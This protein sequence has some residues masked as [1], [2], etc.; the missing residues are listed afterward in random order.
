MKQLSSIT[1]R[2]MLTL[3]WKERWVRVIVLTLLPIGVIDT[4][5]TIAMASLYGVEIEFNPIT[6]E[7][8]N[9]GLWLPWAALNVLGFT[10]FCMMAGSYYLHTRWRPGGPDTFWF[11]FIIALRIGM[12]AYN[13]TFYYMPFVITVYPP[14]WAGFIAF[15]ISLYVMNKLLMRKHDISWSQAKYYVKSRYESYKDSRL[16][17][18]ATQVP[19]QPL[20]NPQVKT[21]AVEREI[22]Q[23]LSGGEVKWYKSP[24]PKRAFFILMAGFSYILMGVAIEVI[25]HVSGL[26]EWSTSHGPFFILNDFTGPPIMASFL[27]I[28]FFMSLSLYFILKAFSTTQEL[29]L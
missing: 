17:S 8:L 19:G 1:A 16:I 5:Y 23:D 13:V 10:F 29:P 9:L 28:I 25:S 6:R 7:L 15:T 11:S 27:A 22:A 4:V 18:H 2:E 24:W 14:F 3:W 26:S 12:A 20:E 21:D